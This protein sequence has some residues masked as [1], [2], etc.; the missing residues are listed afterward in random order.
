MPPL[1]DVPIRDAQGVKDISSAARDANIVRD[2]RNDGQSGDVAFARDGVCLSGA[3]QVS[4]STAHRQAIGGEASRDHR[5]LMAIFL[6]LR[7]A[8]RV[9]YILMMPWRRVG[10]IERN[11]TTKGPFHLE[12]LQSLRGWPSRL[13]TMIFV[14]VS[15][16]RKS[17][18]IVAMWLSWR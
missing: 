4:R 8:S 17:G 15:R 18:L 12:R 9:L 2:C 6:V 1:A 14:G 13:R 10:R 7:P 5:T 3:A 11:W 16:Q